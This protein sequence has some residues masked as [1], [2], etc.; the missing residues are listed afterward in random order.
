MNDKTWQVYVLRCKGGSLYTGITNN[1]ERRLELHNKG[2][3]AKYTRGRRPV[4]LLAT[5]RR[6]AKSDALKLEARVKKA[7]RDEK[8]KLVCPGLTT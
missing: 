2:K 8:V 4:T 1:I 5:S 7:K 6:M 3:G